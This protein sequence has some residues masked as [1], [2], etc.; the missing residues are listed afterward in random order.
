M[1]E[2]KEDW[3]ISEVDSEREIQKFSKSSRAVSTASLPLGR[4]VA[5]S[6]VSVCVCVCV[7]VCCLALV[8]A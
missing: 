3:N 7:Y 1:C 5:A 6:C 8:A 4:F 2:R